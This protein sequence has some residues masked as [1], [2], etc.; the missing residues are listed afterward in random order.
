MRPLEVDLQTKFDVETLR[1]EYPAL[2][3]KWGVKDL[4]YLDNAASLLK[5]RAVIQKQAEFDL[6]SYSNVHRSVHRL[7]EEA[8]N[9][10]EAAREKI[11]EFFGASVDHSV[12]FTKGTT[13]AI[14]LIA[15]SWGENQIESGDCIFVTRMEHH[16]NFVPWQQL[17]KARSAQFTILELDSEFRLDL[18][19]FQKLLFERKPKV[20][21]LSAMSNVTGVINPVQELSA[22]AKKASALVVV[23][24]AQWAAHL[25][26]SI[27]KEWPDVDFVCLSA[28]KLGGPTG[29]G[30]LIGKK[31]I[32]EQLPP[33]QFGGDM[34]LDVSDHETLFN[35]LP[36][37]FEA[38]TPNIS[39]AVGFGYALDFLAERQMKTLGGYE[40]SLCEYALSQLAD[41]P[42]LKMMG[43]TNSKMRGPIFSFSIE[44]IHAHD[45]GSFLDAELIAVRG[46]HHCAQPLHK[47]YSV[48]STTRASFSFYNRIDEVDRLVG[49]LKEAISFFGR[50]K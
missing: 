41:V 39:G 37:K 17:A 19:Q 14:N 27:E 2:S 43:P 48:P 6:Q 1:K 47:F 24:A 20:V 16:A 13:E 9:A 4:A 33:Y 32:L 29:M 30:V 49:T 11:V 15:S 36:L 42:G 31:E 44:G 18:S 34:I 38:G 7:S 50:K 22:L 23:D 21:A 28:H 3:R 46:G 25:P 26:L 10:Y 40:Q 12:V 5:S 8:T 35:E 45:M